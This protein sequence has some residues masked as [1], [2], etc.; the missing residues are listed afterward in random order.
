MEHYANSIEDV[1][2]DALKYKLE[3]GASYIQS[4]R[5]VTWFPSGS[6]IY[7]PISGTRLIRIN[8]NATGE[9]LDP[10][11]LRCGFTVYNRGEDGRVLRTI[12]DPFALFQR[13]RILVGGVVCEDIVDYVRTHNLFQ[14]LTS[15]NDR[16]NDSIEGLSHRWTDTVFHDNNFIFNTDVINRNKKGV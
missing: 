6:A 16:R 3:P 9:W 13:L 15:R 2:V 4:R 10:V 12:G 11:S 7:S 14:T 8:I 5:Q 1:L